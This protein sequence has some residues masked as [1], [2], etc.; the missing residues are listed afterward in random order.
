MTTRKLCLEGGKVEGTIEGLHYNKSIWMAMTKEQRDRAVALHQAKSSQREVKVDTT[1]GSTV[2]ISEVSNK[3]DK[4]A[5]TV[6][7]LNTKS[8]DHSQSTD[9]KFPSI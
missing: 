9:V 7:S 5:R 6:K 2:P 4:L 3:I 1:S 8:A